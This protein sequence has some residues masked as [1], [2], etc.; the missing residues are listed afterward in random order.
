MHPTSTAP[1]VLDPKLAHSVHSAALDTTVHHVPTACLNCNTLVSDRFCGHCGQDAHH[2]HRLTL[3]DMPHDILHSIWHVDKG[4]LYTLKT[5]V[6]R[7]GPTIRAYLA[8]KRVDHFRPLSLLFL[9]TG[10]YALLFSALHIN[11]LPPRDPTMPEA[12]YQMQ[13]SSSAF[14]MKY[15][16]WCYLATVPAWAL[17]ARL[18]LRRG[19]YNYAECL[20][21]AAFITA[22]NNFITLLLLPVTYLYSGTPQIQTFSFY[23]MLLVI[24]YASWAYG[25]LLNHT[26]IGWLSRLWRGFLTFMLGYAM[27]LI[28]GITLMFTL[29]WSSIKQSVKQQKQHTQEQQTVGNQG[30]KATPQ[31][32]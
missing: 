27:L 8:G 29:N 31:L 15:L 23:A 13:A 3:K 20:I 18:F 25:S 22:I 24:G 11:M 6:F 17:A 2:T 21:I 16:T 28:V 5:M 26:T 7:P 32:R 14:F 12:L 19:G 4:I 30:P 9:I 10:V 1:I